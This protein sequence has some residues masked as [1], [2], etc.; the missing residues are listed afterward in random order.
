MH[1]TGKYLEEGCSKQL[2]ATLKVED[3]YFTIEIENEKRH[4]GE[5]KQLKIETRLGNVERKII[6][7]DN[8]IFTTKDNDAVD[9]IFDKK[10]IYKFESKLIWVLVAIVVSMF[11][12]FGFFKWGVPFLSKEIAYALPAKTT[13]LIST[14]AL[15]ILDKHI[16]EKSKLSQK[17]MQD[18]RTHFHV[19]IVPLVKTESNA[20]YKL[21][22]RLYKEANISMPN[23]MALPS[24]DII[25]TDKFVQ[26]CINQAEIDSVLLHEMGHVLHR[27]SL[28][29]LIRSTFIS[30]AVMTILADSNGL[31]DMGVGLGSL[32]V[33]SSY[34]RDNE[35]EADK[36]S[37]EHMLIAGIDPIYFSNIINRMNEYVKKSTNLLIEGDSLKYLSSHPKTQERIDIAKEYSKCFES[38]LVECKILKR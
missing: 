25:L 7:E 20:E 15:E 17:I 4:S 32:L 36:Y 34:S 26:L 9:N 6:L 24:G 19:K 37:F 22:F 16:F 30:V 1:I 5:K 11:F 10:L 2:S 12:A 18:I 31:A 3:N 27:H 38:G 14:S 8:S 29:M 33:N 21:H 28:Q 13:K 23:A 35:A